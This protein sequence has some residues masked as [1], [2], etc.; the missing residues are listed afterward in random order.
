MI[1]Q[2]KM[3]ILDNKTIA[4]DTIELVLEND[5]ISRYASPGQFIHI[6]VEGFTLRRPISIADVDKD[7]K[8]V[9]ILFKTFGD[10]TRKLASYQP[11]QHINVL[12]PLGNGFD[13]CDIHNEKVLLVGGGI[14]IPP[15][16]YLGKKLVENN[17]EIMSILG[18]Q[19][20]ESV[21]YEEKFQA[22]G[23][24]Y[25]V[26]DDGTYGFKGFVTDV[27]SKVNHFD[28]YY[29]CGPTPMLKALQ[30]K[31]VDVN[32]YVSLEERMGC[33]VGACYACVVSTNDETGYKKICQ[34][35]PVFNAREVNL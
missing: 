17:I 7:N 3:L 26:T 30:Q 5:H 21:F 29:S 10:G 22:L 28:R 24:T 32:G 13:L 4:E 25:V 1:K 16:Y 33:G 31:L 18:Y 11:G 6:Q 15:L 9:T 34:D 8:K 19:T 14:G 2:E 27:L 35:G 12:G 23:E 20:A